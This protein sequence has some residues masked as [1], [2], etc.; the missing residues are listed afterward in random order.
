M[1]KTKLF[2]WIPSII[3][4]SLAVVV[5]IIYT[6]I[7]DEIKPI[8]YVQVTASSL[9]PL[10][11]PVWGLISKKKLP[12]ALGF[13]LSFHLFISIDLGNAIGFYDLIPWWDMFLH[14]FWGF[15]GCCVAAVFMVRW[16]GDK[17]TPFGFLAVAA[18]FTMG[19]GAIWEIFE[20][21]SD[22]LLGL[23]TQRVAESIALGKSPVADTMEDLIVTLVGIIVFIVA[24][25]VDRACGFKL[26]R[27][28]YRQTDKVSG[29]ISELITKDE[30]T[31][32]DDEQTLTDGEQ[33][34][35]GKQNDNS[36]NK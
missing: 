34:P 17:L 20:Y 32:P 35:A 2:E 6:F 5:L 3:S 16:G 15:V 29:G 9:V 33:T 10:I 30:Q 13:L 26:C 22:Q 24:V 23:D 12:T 7:T 31:K 1:K 27:I 25:I 4:L 11:L 21:S 18:L 28:F 36:E 19:A 14:G 8:T